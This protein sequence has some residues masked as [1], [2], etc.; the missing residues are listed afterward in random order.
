[1]VHDGH[2]HDSTWHCEAGAVD[3]GPQIYDEF[4]PTQLAGWPQTDDEFEPPQLGDSWPP[5]GHF[6]LPSHA[7]HAPEAPLAGQA[8]ASS[9]DISG[10]ACGQVWCITREK[11][12][13]S[14][15]QRDTA[16]CTL[17]PPASAGHAATLPGC[18]VV[19]VAPARA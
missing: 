11:A 3:Q 15:G 13:V 2:P 16:Q 1:M 10:Q 17:L 6:E 5:L 18:V 12:S 9:S 7:A 19:A 8:A 14:K 4:E